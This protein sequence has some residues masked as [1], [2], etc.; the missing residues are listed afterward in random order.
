MATR[1]RLGVV[2]ALWPPRFVFLWE[3]RRASAG[4]PSLSERAG[5]RKLNRFVQFPAPRLSGL[6][7]L[8]P[9]KRFIAQRAAHEERR[10]AWD[11]VTEGIRKE[12][13]YVG[14]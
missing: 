13:W 4:L 6:R 14:G 5:L 9:A 8:E 1:N 11:A 3:R 2:F 12:G 7:L 10:E